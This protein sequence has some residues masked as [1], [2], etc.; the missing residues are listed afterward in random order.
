MD[1]FLWE[2]G[3]ILLFPTSYIMLLKATFKK[4]FIRFLGF[5]KDNVHI[6]IVCFLVGQVSI[7][8]EQYPCC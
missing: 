4:K 1:G 8:Q 6:Q 7:C 2:T 5:A 3:L